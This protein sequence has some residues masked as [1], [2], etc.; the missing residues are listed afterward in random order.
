MM[1][2]LRS[3]Y[4]TTSSRRIKTRF[5]A[6]DTGVPERLTGVGMVESSQGIIPPAVSKIFPE[7][8]FD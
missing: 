6:P 8:A 7:D 5:G 4:I 3:S 1:L 2:K